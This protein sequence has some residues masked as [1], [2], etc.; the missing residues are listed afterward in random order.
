MIGVTLPLDCFGPSCFDCGVG[1]GP[2]ACFFGDFPTR[3]V[4]TKKSI[5]TARPPPRRMSLLLPIPSVP[6]TPARVAKPAVEVVTHPS[7]A[8]EFAASAAGGDGGAPENRASGGSSSWIGKRRL[9]LLLLS[10]MFIFIE[11]LSAGDPW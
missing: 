6:L 10:L 11:L 4:N 5:A 3:A 9:P 7:L 8:S 2:A 1:S